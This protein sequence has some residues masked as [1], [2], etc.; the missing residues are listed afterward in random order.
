M[1]TFSLLSLAAGLA[2]VVFGLGF[3]PGVQTAEAW[4][5]RD[6]NRK[7]FKTELVKDACAKGGQSAAKKA[8]KKF[9]KAAKKQDSDVNCKSCHK[10]LTPKYETKK[11][12][13]EL[14][15]KFGGK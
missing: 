9:V 13:L 4:W 11:D 12:A 15:K 14:F 10:N 1:K 8:M 2:L 7:E 6:C 3:S 5:G